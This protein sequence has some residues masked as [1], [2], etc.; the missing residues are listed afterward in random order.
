MLEKLSL[1]CDR[2]LAHRQLA[3]CHSYFGIPQHGK[4]IL[5]HSNKDIEQKVCQQ[6]FVY[7]VLL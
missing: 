4:D 6:S 5:I 2:L 7:C 1:A 3:C